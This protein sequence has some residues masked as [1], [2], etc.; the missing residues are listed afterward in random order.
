LLERFHIF[1]EPWPFRPE[2]GAALLAVLRP[3]EGVAYAYP[4]TALV[5]HAAYVDRLVLGRF[6]YGTDT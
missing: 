1:C 6:H 2:T 4:E 3:P 5:V